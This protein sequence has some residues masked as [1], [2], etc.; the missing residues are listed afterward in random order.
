MPMLAST[1][2]FSAFCLAAAHSGSGKTTLAAGLLRACVLRGLAAQGFKCGPDY[3]DPTFHAQA[4]GRPACNIDTWMMGRH[5]VRRLFSRR[6]QDADVAVCEGVMGLLDGKIVPDGETGS[7]V[8]GTADGSTLDTAAALKLP[9]V[10]VVNVRG[11]S[12][13]VAALV[14]GFV[15]FAAA[16][17]VSVAGIIGNQAG[18]ARHAELLSAALSAA[19]LPPLLGT[20]P[21]DP[22]LALPERQL[23][24]V[25][26]DETD[27]SSRL[28]HL[29]AKIEQHIHIDTLLART[30]VPRPVPPVA[31][32][33][34]PEIGSPRRLAV[35][36]DQAFC[37]HY[38][39]NEDMLRQAGWELVPFSPLRDRVIPEASALYLCGGYPEVFAAELASNTSMLA[40]VRAFAASGKEIW[41]ECGGYMYLCREL[42]DTAGQRFP[43]ANVFPATA[44]MGAR[45]KSVGYREVHTTLPFGLSAGAVQV[46]GHEFHWSTIE[47]PDNTPANLAPLYPEQG[48]LAQGVSTETV[49]AGY[50]HLYWGLPRT[51]EDETP[52]PLAGGRV[53]LL[54]GP[55]SAGKTSL[56]H[57]LRRLLQARGRLAMVISMD[58]FLNGCGH[59]SASKAAPH[60]PVVETC[61]AAIA[62]A[63]RHGLLVL[64]DH[65]LGEDPAWLADLLSRLGG[66]PLH[67]I[68]VHCEQGELIRRERGR[69]DRQPDLSHALRQ[70]ASIHCPLPREIEVDTTALPPEACAEWVLKQFKYVNID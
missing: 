42:H 20:L 12:G 60:V 55:S 31:A 56:A 53:L 38:E 17:G 4:S 6:V 24:L 11:M 67:G 57:A 21:R 41:A 15:Q 61:H 26:A 68:Q 3:V 63:A 33:V 48:S 13:S 18:S 8:H 10:L 58:D 62:E 47:W 43:M 9:L 50:V 51:G 54:N 69:T 46:R 23:G 49:R 19:H 37:F 39:E 5:G 44:R 1:P 34:A 7:G 36:K 45:L 30:R 16:R 22:A 70:H 65:V 66:I 32:S 25:P 29:A 59:T 2:E 64:A 28:N 14:S 40:S 52:D 35:A 27:F